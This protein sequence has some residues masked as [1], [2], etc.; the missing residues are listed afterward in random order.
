MSHSPEPLAAASEAARLEWARSRAAMKWCP[1]A[2]DT[3]TQKEIDTYIL[4]AGRIPWNAAFKAGYQ[5]ATRG[6]VGALQE[7]F[8]AVAQSARTIASELERIIEAYNCLESV[9]R[10]VASQIPEVP[11]LS[12]KDLWPDLS[13]LHC[14][15]QGTPTP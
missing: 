6:G 3:P 11:S 2:G 13:H 15:P 1:Q 7:V 4:E 9:C 12:P 14:N 10:N 8:T 5:H